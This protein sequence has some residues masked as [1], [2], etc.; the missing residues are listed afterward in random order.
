MVKARRVRARL[1]SKLGS[2]RILKTTKLKFTVYNVSFLNKF[3]D[4]LSPNAKSGY[5]DSCFYP[6]NRHMVLATVYMTR[7]LLHKD[8]PMRPAVVD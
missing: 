3:Q 6:G 2:Y 7:L 8:A 4:Q 1:R 5:K